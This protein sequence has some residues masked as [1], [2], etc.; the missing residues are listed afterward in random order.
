MK[1]IITVFLL[2][3][4]ISVPFTVK[5]DL[6]D[7]VVENPNAEDVVVEVLLIDSDYYTNPGGCHHDDSELEP[8]ALDTD[9]DGIDDGLED[10]DGHGVFV[11][12]NHPS[13]KENKYKT[14]PVSSRIEEK[15][16]LDFLT[17]NQPK[18]DVESKPVVDQPKIIVKYNDD[19]IKTLP[20]KASDEVLVINTGSGN[21]SIKIEKKVLQ[22]INLQI[23]SGAGDDI[24]SIFG[25][26]YS[27]YGIDN[28]KPIE[29]WKGKINLLDCST[30][31]H[32]VLYYSADIDSLIDDITGCEEINLLK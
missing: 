14:S 17:S 1:K 27:I 3:I 26:D 22:F 11:D 25:I 13:Q 28:D 10:Y 18:W 30:G 12:P 9:G 29:D 8:D 7:F 20:A 4:F 24:I 15:A 19:I 5:S 2:T 32:D 23:S 31:L 6:G 16:I 21:D